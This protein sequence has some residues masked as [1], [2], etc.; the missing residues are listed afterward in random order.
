[1]GSV[2]KVAVNSAL[3]SEGAISGV[4]TVDGLAG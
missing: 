1:M 4:T 3:A 2:T